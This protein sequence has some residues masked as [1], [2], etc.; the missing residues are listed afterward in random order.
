[1]TFAQKYQRPV[2]ITRKPGRAASQPRLQDVEQVNQPSSQVLS[3]VSP[4]G[5]LMRNIDVAN[6]PEGGAARLE[7]WYPQSDVVRPRGGSVERNSGMQIE[8]LSLMVYETGVSRKLFAATS[9]SIFEATT[10]GAVG[11][12]VVTGIVASVWSN[13]NFTTS[14]GVFLV[15][16]ATGN[17]RRLY[18]GATWGT[19]PAITGVAANLLSQV[20]SYS[21]RLFFVES[22]TANAW[23]LTPD[24]VGGAATKFPLG[25]EFKSGGALLAT[26][27]WSSDAGD[28]PRSMW[29]AVS[30]EGDVVVY[31][32]ADPA[33][34]SKRG[35]YKIP[36]PLGI[37]CM[38][39]TG[40][41][42]AIMTEAGLFAMS[43]IVSLDTAALSRES[44]SKNIRT[45]WREIANGQSSTVERWQ[46]V[47][48]DAAGFAIVM[49]VKS[50]QGA[51]QQLVA[52][53][54]TGAWAVWKGWLPTCGADFGGKLVFGTVNGRMMEGDAGGS[55]DGIPYSCVYIGR[56]Q[57][58]EGRTINARF[59]RAI[60]RS[61]ALDPPKV[62]SIFDYSLDAPPAPSASI[63]GSGSLWQPAVFSTKWDRAKWASEAATRQQ[64]QAVT[65]R[66][67]AV[68]PCV[69]YTFAQTTAPSTQL[70]RTDL[71]VDVGEMM[72]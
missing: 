35:N 42:L 36:R 65:G 26:G 48:I 21:N 22:G 8:V 56:S 39:P 55:D 68:A 31:E 19:I 32:G 71:M 59:A 66:G 4:T 47:R 43:Q 30:V 58:I 61:V 10:P 5:G 64:W 44:V 70:I 29:V 67:W 6:I 49:P 45:L 46:M 11:A 14:G 34:W 60:G 63:R 20:S 62:A 25:G 1:M 9:T 52:N 40:G 37:N 50:G 57:M 33:T 17:D 28:S 12:A 38:F 7:N 51:S 54:E 3:F 69:I 24:A 23:Y 16:C 53:M 72:T 18:N 13:I 27:T 2:T 41:D 15:A